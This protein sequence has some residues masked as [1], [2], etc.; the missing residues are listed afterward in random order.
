MYIEHK[1][2]QHKSKPAT[3]NYKRRFKAPEKEKLD[4]EI[5]ELELVPETVSETFIENGAEKEENIDCDRTK[6]DSVIEKVEN[7]NDNCYVPFERMSEVLRNWNAIK[8]ASEK[9]PIKRK[10]ERSKEK[11][12]MTLMNYCE[13]L[14][15]FNGKQNKLM[16]NRISYYLKKMKKEETDPF[17][18]CDNLGTLRWRCKP[19]GTRFQ[20]IAFRLYKIWALDHD[21][22]VIEET[23]DL[24]FDG[25]FSFGR[26]LIEVSY[27]L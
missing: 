10:I 22:E 19:T 14:T 17:A 21:L 26:I 25:N 12:T 9:I 18:G 27:E 7:E 3:K 11:E 4:S 13:D 5:I 15:S 2:D 6:L 8:N 24:A 1:K 20:H 23:C 16:N